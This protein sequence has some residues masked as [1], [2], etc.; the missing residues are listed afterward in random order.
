MNVTFLEGLRNLVVGLSEI[1]WEKGKFLG[2]AILVTLFMTFFVILWVG[3][4]LLFGVELNEVTGPIP[5]KGYRI[6]D[7]GSPLIWTISCIISAG[8]SILIFYG[9]KSILRRIRSN[10][11]IR[12]KKKGNLIRR[13]RRN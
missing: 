4:A 9:I 12:A 13:I 2:A 7:Y 11:E 1:L 3:I 6:M 8:I 10:K 5:V